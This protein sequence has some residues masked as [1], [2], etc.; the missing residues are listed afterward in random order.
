MKRIPIWN[1]KIKNRLDSLQRK[2]LKKIR[3][4]C[5]DIDVFEDNISLEN[6]KGYL[7]Q[8]IEELE[9]NKSVAWES[10]S[11]GGRSFDGCWSKGR[12]RVH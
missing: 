11:N 1:P 6:D 9:Y 4:L 12:W 3:W 5:W 7:N 8:R 2:P 10:T